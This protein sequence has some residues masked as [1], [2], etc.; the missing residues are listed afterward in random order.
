MSAIEAVFDG[1]NFILGDQVKKLEKSISAYSGVAS[2][3]GVSSG[4]DALLIALMALDIK[5]GDEVIT[6]PYTFFSTV[7]AIVRLGAKPIFVDIDPRS[8]NIDPQKIESAISKKT[9]CIIPVHLYGQVADMELIIDVAEKN[10]ITIVEDAAQAIGAQYKNGKRAGSMGALGCFSFFPSK[11][12]GCLGDGGMVVFQ[13]QAMAE[14]ITLLRGHGAKPKYHHKYVGG[15]F[16]LD[17]MQAAVLNVKLKYLDEWTFTRQRNAEY[18][19]KIFGK[20]FLT[21]KKFIQ[22]PQNLY[23]ENELTHGHIY[24]QYVIRSKY[25]DKLILFLNKNEIGCEVYYPVPLHL[26]ECFRYLGYTPGDFPESEK[27]AKETVAL[28]IYPGLTEG[29]Q[30]FVISTLEKFYE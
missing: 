28:P 6:T 18:Y 21:K 30:N 12:L 29:Q 20:S 17:A 9:K 25:R 4:T 10:H 1:G 27:A 11:N 14:K 3:V 23:Q 13:D 2:A 16:R 19:D 15:N 5:P 24:N 7:G 22:I 8:Y 26:Q